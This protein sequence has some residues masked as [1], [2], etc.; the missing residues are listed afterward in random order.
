MRLFLAIQL[1]DEMKAALIESMHG[2]KKLGVKGRFIPARN[3]HLTLAFLGEYQDATP[4]KTVLDQLK[5]KPFRLSLTQPG[6]FG[7]LLWIGV[8]GNQGLSALVKDLRTGL[9]RA[10]LEYDRKAFQPHITI[11]R[12]MNGS[13]QKLPAPKGEM[14]VKQVSLMRSDVRDGQRVYTELYS[15]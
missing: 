12:E 15:V 14:M 11:V 1:S 13:W 10:G 5:Y 8:K 2:L 9:D 4:V 6:V 7:N 3:L